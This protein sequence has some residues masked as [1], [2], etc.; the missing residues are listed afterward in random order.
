MQN[1]DVIWHI[2]NHQFCSFKSKIAKE[3]TFCQNPYSVSGLCIRSACP[4]AN[5]RYATIREE[6]GVCYLFM[7][8]IERAH[9]PKNLWEKIKLPASYAKALEIVSEKLEHFPKYL[10]HRNKQ[11]LTKIHQML[12]RMRKLKLKARPKIVTT[13]TKLEQ[14][15]VGKE[16][17]ALKAAQIDRAI[18]KE[19]LDR[20]KQVTDGEIYNYPEREY[21]KA[22]KRASHQFE[23]EDEEQEYEDENNSQNLE[24]E[25]DLDN[26]DDDDDQQQYE[27]QFVEDFEESD[28]EN[29]IEEAS[30]KLTTPFS[31]FYSKRQNASE[32]TISQQSNRKSSGK[33]DKSNKLQAK[34]H[35]RKVARV[36]IEYEDED[37]DELKQKTELITE[38]N[39]LSKY[40]TRS[41]DMDYNF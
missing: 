3:R 11:R 29:N 35:K 26:D 4:L 21:N 15:E 10:V 1:D 19:L 2:I 38:M 23:N 20:L 30:N 39:S 41:T 17:K 5:S 22:L 7:K 32:N 33:P 31:S 12:I 24:D 9:T 36:E 37:F 40:N 6:D 28:E 14:R 16:R 18:E 13:N 27:V 25:E 8:T 34:P